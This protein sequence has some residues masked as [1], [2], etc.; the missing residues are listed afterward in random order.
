MIPG[1]VH[2]RD[3]AFTSK[4]ATAPTG[5]IGIMATTGIMGTTVKSD[6]VGEKNEANKTYSES[7]IFS[8]SGPKK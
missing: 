2:H 8:F 1:T 7:D 5:I 3:I 6:T 4:N